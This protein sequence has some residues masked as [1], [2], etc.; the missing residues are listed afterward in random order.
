LSARLPPAVVR[1]MAT[2]LVLYVW[3]FRGCAADESE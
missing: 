3:F 2:Y 1:L